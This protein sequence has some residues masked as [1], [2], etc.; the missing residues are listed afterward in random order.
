VLAEANVGARQDRTDLDGQLGT[1]ATQSVG[2]TRD[3]RVERGQERLDVGDPLLRLIEDGN[4]VDVAPH[5]GA[6]ARRLAVNVRYA[7]SLNVGE[8]GVGLRR[9]R[10]DLVADEAREVLILA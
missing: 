9:L 2:R 7:V 4:L 10:R 6:G 1:V 8:R 5:F 3:L